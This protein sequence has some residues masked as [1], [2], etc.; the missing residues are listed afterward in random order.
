[1]TPTTDDQPAPAF[2]IRHRKALTD[3]LATLTHHQL[4]AITAAHP[5][6]GDPGHDAA[7]IGRVELIVRTLLEVEGQAGLLEAIAATDPETLAQDETAAKGYAMLAR[8]LTRTGHTLPTLTTEPEPEPADAGADAD[9]DKGVQAT[10]A[11]IERA[12]VSGQLVAV[13]GSAGLR[14]QLAELEGVEVVLVE[15]EGTRGQALAVLQAVSTALQTPGAVI[16]VGGPSEM[17]AR[18]SFRA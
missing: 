2:T 4:D 18:L 12:P 10:S 15:D 6:P 5:V 13:G 3:V 1:M 9:A 14:S 16:A 11:S 8:R 7:K 17:L